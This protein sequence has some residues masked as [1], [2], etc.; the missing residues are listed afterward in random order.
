MERAQRAPE[1]KPV[2]GPNCQ[3]FLGRRPDLGSEPAVMAEKRSEV[4]G[5]AEA[6]RVADRSSQL[7]RLAINLQGLVRVAKV[8]QGQR[9]IATVRHARVMARMGGPEPGT[10]TVVVRGYRLLV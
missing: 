1:L 9:E 6:E 4:H 7:L 8:P 10:L 5:M 2:F 3:L